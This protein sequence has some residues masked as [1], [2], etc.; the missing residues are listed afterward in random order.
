MS[1]LE[2]WLVEFE[3]GG[4]HAAGSGCTLE[5]VSLEDVLAVVSGPAVVAC[6]GPIERRY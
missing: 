5:E 3:H 1:G 2:A 4:N 6:E